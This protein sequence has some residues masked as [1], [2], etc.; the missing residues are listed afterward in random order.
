MS[1]DVYGNSWTQHPQ[2]QPSAQ[3]PGAAQAPQYA[4]HPN[5]GWQAGPTLEPVARAPSLVLLVNGARF[6]LGDV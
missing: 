4:Y 5:Y 6:D 2:A 3:Q 1:Q